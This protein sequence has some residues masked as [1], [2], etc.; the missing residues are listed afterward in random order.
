MNRPSPVILPLTISA[1]CRP[2]GDIRDTNGRRSVSFQLASSNFHRS[3]RMGRL[4]AFRR[5]RSLAERSLDRS[6]DRSRVNPIVVCRRW[7][8]EQTTRLLDCVRAVQRGEIGTTFYD[9][10]LRRRERRIAR[11]GIARRRRR[12]RRRRA[13]L[14]IDGGGD[15]DRNQSANRVRATTSGYERLQ[16]SKRKGRRSMI[17][18]G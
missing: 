8:D 1:S 15:R 14:Q 18:A 13:K 4:L 2:R 10:F 11:P 17:S 7:I 16:C 9:L 3:L 5:K 12:R 6:I